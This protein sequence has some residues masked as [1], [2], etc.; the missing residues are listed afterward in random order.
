[1]VLEGTALEGPL[2]R[3]GATAIRLMGIGQEAEVLVDKAV[4]RA[5]SQ[6]TA[7][8]ILKGLEEVVDEL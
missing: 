8:D 6:K 4:K 7:V 5:A 3:A 2:P 1:M